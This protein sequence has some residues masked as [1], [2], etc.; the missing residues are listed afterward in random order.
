M[1]EIFHKFM[2]AIKIK[3]L[4]MYFEKEFI[5]HAI[6]Y[7]TTFYHGE[8]IHLPVLCELDI[9][10]KEVVTVAIAL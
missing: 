5:H 6:T 4:S 1:L 8:N 7:T 9:R 2:D 3:K 10:G